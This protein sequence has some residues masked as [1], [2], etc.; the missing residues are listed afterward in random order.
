MAVVHMRSQHSHCNWL[1]LNVVLLGQNT[2]AQFHGHHQPQKNPAGIDHILVRHLLST[3]AL[4]YND[5]HECEFSQGTI[6][7]EPAGEHI[8][9]LDLHDFNVGGLRF[10]G[11]TN[12]SYPFA[13]LVHF[14]EPWHLSKFGQ[15][16]LRQQRDIVAQRSDAF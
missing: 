10:L 3:A 9:V 6:E 15:P 1:E 7:A 14:E 11:R 5:I 8:S 13:T 2:E 12:C 16:R 4:C